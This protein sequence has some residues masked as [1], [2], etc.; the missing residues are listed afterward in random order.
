MPSSLADMSVRE[1]RDRADVL[2]DEVLTEHWS[3]GTVPVD[4]VRIAR[5]MGVEVFS[6]QL[7]NDVFGMIFGEPEGAQIYIDV[8][9]PPNRYRFTAAHEL[10]HYVEHTQL[11]EDQQWIER[12]GGDMEYVDRRT[13]AD[14]G[15]PEEVFANQFAG[16]L[17]MPASA[18]RRFERQNLNAVTM[19]S[20]FGV[21]LDALK[22]RRLL[23]GRL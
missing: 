19:A 18:V 17:L 2:A 6:A 20:R 16:A 21:S 15:R 5:L 14:R 13:D 10:G 4:P 7:G 12:T 11:I 8:D 23:L 9:Q 1:I 22:Y 3:L